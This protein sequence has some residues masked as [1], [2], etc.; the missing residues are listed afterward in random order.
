M[1]LKMLIFCGNTNAL[2]FVPVSLNANELLLSPPPFQ[3]RA[4]PLQLVP[5]KNICF[6]SDYHVYL[7]EIM[8]FKLY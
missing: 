7:A 1:I 4:A 8:R 2:I 5:D 6:G 3:S